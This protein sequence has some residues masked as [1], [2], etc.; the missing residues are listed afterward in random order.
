MRTVVTGHL[1]FI[2]QHLCKAIGESV[3]GLDIK[4]GNDIRNCELPDADKVY[5]LA[6]Q[7]DAACEDAFIDAETNIMGSLRI[8]ER[9]RDK[10]VFAST[11]MI[12]YPMSPYAISKGAAEHYAR[13]YDCSVVR[14][15]NIFGPGGHSVVDRFEADETLTIHGTGKQRREFAHVDTAVSAL[16]NGSMSKLTI[17]SGTIMTVLELAAAYKNKWIAPGLHRRF[18][19]VDG[20]HMEDA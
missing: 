3:M 18:D 12:H 2:G 19:L 8:F 7:T 14:L 17:V 11:S 10:V 20:V 9:Y 5:H 16:L 1:G 13:I 4:E 15:C 6:A